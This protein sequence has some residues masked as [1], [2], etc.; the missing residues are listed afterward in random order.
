MTT[1]DISISKT[2]HIS[3]Y[4]SI[5]TIDRAGI[6]TYIFLQKQSTGA[7]KPV[8]HEDKYV[9][10]T[11]TGVTLPSGISIAAG[12]YQIRLCVNANNGGT[13]SMTLNYLRCEY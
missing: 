5:Q 8:V 12:T 7:Y 4:L 3:P 9:A 2:E 11:A 13:A 6:I 1:P 10:A